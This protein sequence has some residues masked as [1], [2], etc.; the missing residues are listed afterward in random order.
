MCSA[1]HQRLSA[2]ALGVDTNDAPVVERF[3][4]AG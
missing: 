4:F 2:P 3:R 1:F